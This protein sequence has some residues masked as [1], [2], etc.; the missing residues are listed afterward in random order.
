LEEGIDYQLVDTNFEIVAAL[1]AH[2]GYWKSSDVALFII[3][4][5]CQNDKKDSIEIR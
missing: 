4:Q 5:L 2:T 3:Q 1:K